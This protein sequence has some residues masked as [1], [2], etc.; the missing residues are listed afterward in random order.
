MNVQYVPFCKQLLSDLGDEVTRY[1]TQQAPTITPPATTPHSSSATIPHSTSATIPHSSSQSTPWWTTGE[2]S[3]SVQF[4]KHSLS[5]M[6]QMRCAHNTCVAHF[7]KNNIADHGDFFDSCSSVGGKVTL[8][9]SNGGYHE[10]VS[11]RDTFVDLYDTALDN[12]AHP[13]ARCSRPVT[14]GCKAFNE[15]IARCLA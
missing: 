12:N 9:T 13:R 7:R 10:N 6:D 3:S 14:R 4:Q 5:R 8:T 2:I 15:S 1:R 11:Q